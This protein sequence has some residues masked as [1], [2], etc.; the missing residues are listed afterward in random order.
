MRTVTSDGLVG[1][2][3]GLAE[4][5]A[6]GQQGDPQVAAVDALAQD[7]D[8]PLGDDEELAAVLAFDDQ[9]VAQRDRLPS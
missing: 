5:L 4:K 8:L 9:L 1:D 7:L 3:I 2:E 6:F